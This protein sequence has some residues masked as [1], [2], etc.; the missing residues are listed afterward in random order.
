VQHV[1]ASQLQRSGQVASTAEDE[2]QTVL[3]ADS[4]ALRVLGRFVQGQK[5]RSA[6]LGVLNRSIDIILTQLET[7]QLE[8]AQPDVLIVPQVADIRPLNFTE[9]RLKIYR[10]GVE[11]ARAQEEALRMLA[12]RLR[13]R[14]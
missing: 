5:E 6:A 9:D 14:S 2:S 4:M 7:H 8:E 11:A 1:I 12:N 13:M 3:P 10:R